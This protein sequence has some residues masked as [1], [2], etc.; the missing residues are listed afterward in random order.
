MVS[1]PGKNQVQIL[2][3]RSCMWACY[4][5]IAPLSNF[6]RPSTSSILE[7]DI[8]PFSSEAILESPKK[9][10]RLIFGPHHLKFRVSVSHIALVCRRA[11]G[12]KK[13]LGKRQEARERSDHLLKQ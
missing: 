13:L 3:I 8:R 10:T 7:K 6:D 11:A 12:E 5:P 2:P 9:S 1:I 4:L